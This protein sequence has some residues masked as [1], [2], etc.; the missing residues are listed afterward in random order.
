MYLVKVAE[1]KMKALLVD[2]NP[3]ALTMLS[4]ALQNAGYETVVAG[5]G[6]EALERIPTAIALAREKHDVVLVDLHPWAGAVAAQPGLTPDASLPEIFFRAS[7]T[8]TPIL[9]GQ[10]DAVTTAQVR[11][12]GKIMMQE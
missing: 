2:D 11:E 4:N 1:L 3:I 8:S 10:P 12:L 7:Q 9:L 6:I 5:S